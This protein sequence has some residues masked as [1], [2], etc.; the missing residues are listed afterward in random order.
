MPKYFLYI[1]IFLSVTVFSSA[2]T[3]KALFD[4]TKNETAGNADWIIDTQ[5]PIPSPAQSG[6]TPSTPETYWLG[7]ISAW[8][9]DLV[10]LGFTVHTLT[11]T[12]GITYGNTSNP[13]DL[14][15]YNLFIVCEPQNPFSVAEKLAIKSYVQ[16]GGG[17]MMVADHNASDR[18]SDG[19][20]SPEVWNDL[21]SDSLFGIH[22]QSVG[23]T[24]NNIV[25]VYTN[26]E[27]GTD[28]II[29]G[30]AG[31]V[32]A[33]SYH[34]GTTMRLTS[35]NSSAKGHIWMN[36]IS[37]GTTQ[38]VAATSRYG[39]GKV[40][41][42]G[43]SSPADDST[44]QS[45]N[46]LYNGWTEAGATDNI[47][48]LNMSLWLVTK[49]QVSL[50]AQVTLLSPIDLS[51]ATA[52]PTIFRWQKTATATKYQFDLSTSNTFSTFVVS[53]SSIIDTTTTIS[54]LAL[55]TTYYWR[56]RAKNSSGWG[57]YSTIRSFT[58]W[59]VPQQVILDIPSDATTNAAI[60]LQCKWRKESSAIK[61]EFDLSLSSSFASFV[62][63]DS[64]ITDTLKSI[65]E[66]TLNT[67]YY[68]RVRAKNNAGWGAY[69]SVWSF[70]TWDIPPPVQLD[71][72][73]DSS[74]DLLL[75]IVCTWHTVQGVVN[76]KFELASDYSF[77]TIAISDSNVVDYVFTIHNLSG[78]SYYWRVSAKNAAGWGSLSLVRMFS[79]L[80]A[81]EQVQ[82]TSPLNG[83]SGLPDT[84]PFAWNSITGI[85]RYNFQISITNSFDLIIYQDSTI[86][87]TT[88]SI[89]GLDSLQ[90]YYWR[91]R[92][93]NAAG[94]GQ[95]SETWL[96]TKADS[97]VISYRFHPSWNIV[98]LPFAQADDRKSVIF[99]SVISMAFLY[100]NVYV[101]CE[102]LRVGH[103]YWIKFD[104]AE[105]ITLKGIPNPA[106]TLN[107]SK[108]WNLIGATA[109]TYPV[110]LISTIPTGIII[111]EF[112]QY[113]INYT[114]SDSLRPMIGYWLKVSQSGQLILNNSVKS[115]VN[116]SGIFRKS[117]PI[118]IK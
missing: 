1:F 115:S 58:T 81:P 88:F 21:R 2:Q 93:A 12:Y 35:S 83:I 15:N 54:G 111:S 23:E 61:Y 87:D 72:P 62:I 108:G 33:L 37:H 98:S 94:W 117:S 75:P 101:P 50:P 105:T 51:T 48:F 113:D 29:H 32:T 7:A 11:T 44:G 114:P 24:N 78:G 102:S 95:F 38:I 28:T 36:S 68:W 20:D 70:T 86:V 4:N 92:A 65:S 89:T 69:S 104:S 109:N 107:V 42:V 64:T 71:I 116:V 84:I 5:Q 53:D 8:G 49:D 67:T 10:K 79:V 56:V 103:G 26:V 9:V 60:P 63:L 22:F 16:N 76:Y 30:T 46:N 6:I 17:L 59:N 19:W 77:S 118:E 40:G 31:T 112:Y 41:A 39:S 27:T 25:G 91:V 66:L 18:D 110:G 45:G 74:A 82:L 14:S 96:F 100:D 97:Q 80:G 99:P 47:L 90:K 13:Y 34:N 106:E 3:Y 55:S 85:S 52:I 73:A 57:A 43:D